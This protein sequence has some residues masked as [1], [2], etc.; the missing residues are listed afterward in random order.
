MP[1]Q[2]R[3][4]GK[5]KTLCQRH[6][7]SDV[8]QDANENA[9][10]QGHHTPGVFQDANEKAVCQGHHMTSLRE[11]KDAFAGF[12]WRFAIALKS[13]SSESCAIRITGTG[14]VK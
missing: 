10:C 12:L 8:F 3:L 14:Y 4:V 7:T 13:Q 11:L 6:H 5:R 2:H 9:R 1:C